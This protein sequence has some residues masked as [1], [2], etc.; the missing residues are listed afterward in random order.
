MKDSVNLKH[1]LLT[2][3]GE[4]QSFARME[5][6]SSFQRQKV[7]MLRGLPGVG[8]TTLSIELGKTLQ[9]PVVCKDDIRDTLV[10]F[11]RC[12]NEHFIE[13]GVSFHVDSNSYCYDIMMAL[14][15]TQLK[16]GMDVIVESPL[17]RLDIYNRFV[18]LA[19]EFHA[20]PIV[21]DCVL[22]EALWRARLRSRVESGLEPNHKPQDPDKVL[23]YYRDSIHFSVAQGPR[24]EVDMSESK[25]SI[26][27][28]VVELLKRVSA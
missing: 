5:T 6:K 7:V 4:S 14:A 9:I 22:D 13:A 28:K 19:E 27:K 8:K 26:A 1:S 10:G 15:K 16:C 23:E 11:D 18:Q 21:V 12:C 17:G 3:I 24:I 2:V 20:I 25:E